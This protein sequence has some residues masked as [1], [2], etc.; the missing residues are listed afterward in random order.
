MSIVNSG[1]VRLPYR[2]DIDGLRAVAVTV[3]VLFHAFPNFFPGG[4]IGVDVFF[5]ISGYLI[6]AIIFSERGIGK[7]GSGR[8]SFKEF[9][10][11]RACRILPALLIMLTFALIAAWFI[12]LPD[13]FRRFGGHIRGAGFYVSNLV[14]KKE[15]GYFDVAAETKP[16]LHLWSLA[17]EE[18]F[19]IIWPVIAVAISLGR[20][21]SLLFVAVLIMLSCSINVVN[22][23]I[24]Q[25][26]V[27]YMP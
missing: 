14:L 27:F 13:D 12:L 4:F 20:R 8:F 19:Y 10:I 9:Y 5:V 11:R 7:I 26:S 23:N 3:V 17:I 25:V 2:S 21:K 15:V 16:L 1:D 22:V 24:D 6:S 18:Q